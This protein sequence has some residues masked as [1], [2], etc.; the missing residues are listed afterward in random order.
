M[1]QPVRIVV[2][3]ALR[4]RTAIFNTACEELSILVALPA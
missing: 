1:D 3:E 2:P 4:L